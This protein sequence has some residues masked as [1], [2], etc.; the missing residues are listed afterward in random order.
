MGTV[1]LPQ[2]RPGHP[3]AHTTFSGSRGTRTHNPPA[4][5]TCFQDR[6]L[7]PSDDFRLSSILKFEISDFRFISGS[8][9]RTS[10]AWFRAK[11]RDQPQLPRSCFLSTLAIRGEGFEPPSSASKTDIRPLDDPRECLVGVEPTYPVWKTGTFAARP[12][13]RF[14]APE[15]GLEPQ[16]AD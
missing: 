7:I 2:S 3:P 4:A 5:D 16:S 10:A 11:H 13:T 8:W 1:D 14:T 15:G 9:N 12:K 6:L